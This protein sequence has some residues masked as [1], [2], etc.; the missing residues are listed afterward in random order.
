MFRVNARNYLEMFHM[1]GTTPDMI[2]RTMLV[3]GKEH[4][5]AAHALGRG[6]II[7]TGHF[8]PY[9]YMIQWLIM[10]GYEGLIP[11]ESLKNQRLLDLV[12]RLRSSKGLEIV[13]LDGSNSL[14]RL[15][16]GL[17]K[18]KV[19]VLT[20]DR[21]FPGQQGQEMDLFGEKT[22]LPVGVASLAKRTGA[23]V[24]G[25]FGWWADGQHV[26]GQL[27]PVSLQLSEEERRDTVCLQKEIVRGLETYIGARPE[28]W[29]AF[30]PIWSRE[31][32]KINQ[33]KKQ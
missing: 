12:T 4:L 2:R 17:K 30:S 31:A 10:Q 33:A 7:F 23:A 22:L 20:A 18:N 6:V 25:A 15:L 24:V 8:G 11:V 16:A 13:P 14:K 28:Q 29:I 32:I 5:D 26:H 3:E 1:P 19:M 9:D 27:F 21:V